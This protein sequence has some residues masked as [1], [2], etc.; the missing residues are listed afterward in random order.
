MGSKKGTNDLVYKTENSLQIYEMNL[1]LP[2]G[3][4][5]GEIDYKIRTDINTTIYKIDN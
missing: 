1:W 3:V 4:M 5:L 2:R